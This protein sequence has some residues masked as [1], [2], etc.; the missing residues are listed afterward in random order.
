VKWQ[1]LILI[2]NPRTRV[3]DGEIVKIQKRPN[4][5]HIAYSL[6]IY[7]D[8]DGNIVT[9]DYNMLIINNTGNNRWKHG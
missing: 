1:K 5:E 8:P 9:D 4:P 2:K 3:V 7:P 6:K